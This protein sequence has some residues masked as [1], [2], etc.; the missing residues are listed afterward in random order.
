M[1]LLS[2]LQNGSSQ[3]SSLDGRTPNTPNFQ[4]STLHKDYSTIGDPD[5]ARVRPENGVLPLPSTMERSVIENDKYL[6]N[7]PR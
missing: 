7:L 2:K 1:G 6:N 5:A 3:L 4:Q